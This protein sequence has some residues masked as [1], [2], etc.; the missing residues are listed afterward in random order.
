MRNKGVPMS[1]TKLTAVVVSALAAL[2]VAIAPTTATAA[3]TDLPCGYSTAGD[4][5]LFNNC[6]DRFR[7]V[8]IVKFGPIPN[9]YPCL[10][11][12]IVHADDS[13]YI[14]NIRHEHWGCS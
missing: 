4:L 10:L 6:S 1:K 13:N 2:G 5:H 3:A 12:G 14:T 8:E 7:T 11:P 9:E